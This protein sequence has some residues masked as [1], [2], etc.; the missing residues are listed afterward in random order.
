MTL[1]QKVNNAL[2]DLESQLFPWDRV[3]TKPELG[4]ANNALVHGIEMIDTCLDEAQGNTRDLK[5][6]LQVTLLEMQVADYSSL[7]PMYSVSSCKVM[8][9]LE[10]L[11]K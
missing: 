10:K 8:E 6:Y 1:T 2:V 7:D 9:V 3:A 4:I 11:L 5:V